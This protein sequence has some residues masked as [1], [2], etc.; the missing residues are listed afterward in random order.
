MLSQMSFL[1]QIIKLLKR[2]YYHNQAFSLER[3]PKY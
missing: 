3:I 2:K 1:Q